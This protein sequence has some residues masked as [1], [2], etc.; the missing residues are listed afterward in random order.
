MSRDA[1]RH[2]ELILERIAANVCTKCGKF[3]PIK[4][5]RRCEKCRAKI[6]HHRQVERDP[7]VMVSVN[8]GPSIWA[9]SETD[10]DR[11]IAEAERDLR[12][13]S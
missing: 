9:Y 5:E 13:V 1:D 3:P 12:L 10:L 11:A 6:A 4:G 8:E 2:H 7:T